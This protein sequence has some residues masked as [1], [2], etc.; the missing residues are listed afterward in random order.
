MAGMSELDKFVHKFKSLW[1]SG[2][3]VSLTVNVVKGIAQINLQVN[4]SLERK[5][6]GNAWIKRSPR[7]GADS[8]CKQRRRARREAERKGKT[9]AAKNSAGKADVI[10]EVSCSESEMSEVTE[11]QY[12]VVFNTQ[13]EVQ[14]FD[15][16]E[17]L[18]ENGIFLL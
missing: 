18:E 9:N 14:N 15:R 5:M 2:S 4:V 6:P 10:Q 13:K 1:E 3:D 12:E 17:A 16:V 11:A 7:K 8:P